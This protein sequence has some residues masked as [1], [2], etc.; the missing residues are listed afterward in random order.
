MPF[1]QANHK[2]ALEQ[3]E[4]VTNVVEEHLD[5]QYVVE[6]ANHPH[7]CSLLSVVQNEKGKNG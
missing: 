3:S 2:S 5:Y 4:F 7:I 6:V 1:I